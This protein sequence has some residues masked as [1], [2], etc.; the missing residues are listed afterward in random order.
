MITEHPVLFPRSL[1]TGRLWIASA[2]CKYLEGRACFYD[3][4]SGEHL[5]KC[6]EL[7]CAYMFP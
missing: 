3:S 7:A 6:L 2:S 5:K 4:D 1:S